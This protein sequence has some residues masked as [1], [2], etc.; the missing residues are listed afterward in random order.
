MRLPRR[1]RLVIALALMNICLATLAVV[2][3]SLGDPARAGSAT[4]RATEAAARGLAVGPGLDDPSTTGGQAAG[5]DSNDAAED[6]GD[7]AAGGSADRGTDRRTESAPDGPASTAPSPAETAE[8][9]AS[10]GPELA[11][12]GGPGATAVPGASGSTVAPAAT[13]SAARTMP[14]TDGEWERVSGPGD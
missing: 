14:P 5:L 1:S 7:D 11:P 13:D 2:V 4:G 9:A 10:P 8:T 12:R 3:G 6:W